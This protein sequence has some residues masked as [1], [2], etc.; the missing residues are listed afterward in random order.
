M[1]LVTGGQQGQVYPVLLS[2]TEVFKTGDEKWSERGSLP[3]AIT[4]LTAGILDN[5]IFLLG[6][7]KQYVRLLNN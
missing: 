6:M 4:A 3:K 2:S 7:K 1:F 5:D